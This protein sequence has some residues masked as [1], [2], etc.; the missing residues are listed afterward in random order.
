[1]LRDCCKELV[2]QVLQ[3]MVVRLDDEWTT[4]QV[5]SPMADNVE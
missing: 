4:P 5:R 1:M 2:E 3:A